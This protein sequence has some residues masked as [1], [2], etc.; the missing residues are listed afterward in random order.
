MRLVGSH[1]TV[2]VPAV[3][4][5]ERDSAA[6]G[7]PFFIMNRID[8]DMVADNPPYVFGG[9]LAE[10]PK[11][12]QQ[13]VQRGMI[14]VLAGIHGV[15][16]S[17]DELAFLQVPYPGETPLRRY[18][19]WKKSLYEWGRSG[20]RFP[21]IERLIDWLEAHWPAQEGQ[22]VVIWGDAR[23]ANVL[24]RDFAPASPPAGSRSTASGPRSLPTSGYRPATIPGACATVS[25]SRRSMSN[26]S[27]TASAALTNFS[28]ARSTWNVRTAATTPSSSTTVWSIAPTVG[29][30]P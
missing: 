22:P 21:L 18:V 29:P 30:R 7:V 26:R 10:A 9:W 13:H 28:G 16:A 20:M 27:A 5:Q 15:R 2:P 6:L 1:C 17:A 3:P 23:P 8:G 19:A 25:A 24:W 4:W 12:R 14:D 11:D